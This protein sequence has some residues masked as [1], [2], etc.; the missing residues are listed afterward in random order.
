MNCGVGLE[1]KNVVAEDFLGDGVLV[2][3]F[4]VHKDVAVVVG[5]EIFDVAASRVV[6]SMSSVAPTRLS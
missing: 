4:Q 2:V 5:I 3:G 1:I 6:V